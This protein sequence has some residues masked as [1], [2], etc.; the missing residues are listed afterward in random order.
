MVKNSSKYVLLSDIV[1]SR[2]IKDRKGFE[3]KL[4]KTLQQV[5][6]RYAG[7]FE[8]PIQVWKGL[9][10]TAAMLN[11]PWHLYKVMDAIDAGIA[12]ERMR[13]VLVKGVVDVLPKQGTIA[14]ADGAAFHTAA[15]E[16]LLL[17]KSGLKFS[18]QTGNK[19]FDTA[20]QAQVN[21]LWLVKQDWTERQRSLYRLYGETG[22]QEEVAK[23]LNISQQNVSKTLKSIAATQVQTLEKGLAEWTE[24][25]LKNNVLD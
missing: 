4:T 15:A 6:E 2:K 22:L 21:L 8:M 20:W 16:M 13:F 25:S 24:T 9:D 23:R 19:A 14:E 12:P 10:E 11:E 18:C 1:G 3:T 17:K 5:Q 7:I